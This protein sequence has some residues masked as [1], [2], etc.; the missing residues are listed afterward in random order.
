MEVEG[1]EPRQVGGVRGV[2]GGQRAERRDEARADHRVAGDGV[3]GDDRAVGERGRGGDEHEAGEAVGVGE[4]VVEREE[5]PIGVADQDHALGAM[6][7]AQGV[8]VLD[9]GRVG[10][11]L[12]DLGRKPFGAA[13]PALVDVDEG[14]LVGERIE[15]RRQAGVVEA[16]TTMERDDER[17]VADPLDPEVRIANGHSA[18]EGASPGGCRRVSHG[19]LERGMEQRYRGARRL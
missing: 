9:Q 6:G 14:R 2:V 1:Q 18:R 12:P 8:D 7:R 5:A 17:A 13:L 16:E 11:R 19:R 3:A 10:H 15:P 4:C